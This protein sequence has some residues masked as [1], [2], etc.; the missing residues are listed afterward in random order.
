MPTIAQEPLD[1][2]AERIT[3][4]IPAA[5]LPLLLKADPAARLHELEAAVPSSWSEL[6]S[7]GRVNETLSNWMAY[8]TRYGV[9]ELLAQRLRATRPLDIEEVG[10]TARHAFAVRVLNSGR[11]T[12]HER[13]VALLGIRSG[14][15]IRGAEIASEAA[16]I[17][18][19]LLATG[20]LD[21]GAKSFAGL[22]DAE[23]RRTFL[24][25]ST[26]FARSPQEFELAP[27]DLLTMIADIELAEITQTTHGAR[28]RDRRAP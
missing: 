19:E 6:L 20:Q 14:I 17:V 26:T 25:R 5:V 8:S 28:R 23:S 24:A 11:L 3:T 15:P 1:G 7:A 18:D 22:P 21:D 13:V 2:W 12:P 9:D 4:I 16:E 27:A 10:A